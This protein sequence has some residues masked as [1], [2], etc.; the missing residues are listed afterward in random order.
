MLLGEFN[1]KSIINTIKLPFASSSSLASGIRESYIF[2]EGVLERKM[3]HKYIQRLYLCIFLINS[4]II[5]YIGIFI[6]DDIGDCVVYGV[7]L[8]QTVC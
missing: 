8:K 4:H 2:Y 1:L 5:N 6:E 3:E 7:G